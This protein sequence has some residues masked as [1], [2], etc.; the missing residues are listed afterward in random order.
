[1]TLKKPRQ[2][3]YGSEVSNFL[4]FNYTCKPSKMHDKG[5]WREE[6]FKGELLDL[7]TATA[8]RTKLIF[9]KLSWVHF[10]AFIV[11]LRCEKVSGATF[12]RWRLRVFL[13]LS[14]LGYGPF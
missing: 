14:E 5:T 9:P 1:M 13:S 8:T 2:K 12:Y 7:R 3:C 10:Y 6:G 4:I 11:Q